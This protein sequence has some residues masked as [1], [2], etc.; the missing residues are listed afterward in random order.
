MKPHE[1]TFQQLF[2][3]M[4]RVMPLRSALQ[5]LGEHIVPSMLAA[6]DTFLDKKYMATLSEADQEQYFSL[7]VGMHPELAEAN[8]IVTH[9]TRLTEALDEWALPLIDEF[10]S[11][12]GEEPFAVDDAY[13]QAKDDA[14]G[15]GIQAALGFAL[16]NKAQ[17]LEE[18]YGS[19]LN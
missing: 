8:K 4:N 19:S 5:H 3:E 10:D 2:V 11:R 6:V 15:G 17:F 16:V 7:Q 1:M 18:Y 12:K 9:M 13:N 14:I